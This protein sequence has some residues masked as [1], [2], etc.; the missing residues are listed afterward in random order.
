MSVRT[1]LRLTVTMI[2][3]VLAGNAMGQDNLQ[4]YF[5]GAA[6]KVKATANPEQK[7]EILNNS[8]QAMSTAL[9]RVES[10]GL[11]SKDDRAG[12]DRFKASLQE[13]QDELMGRNGYERVPDTQLNAFSNYVVQDM[14]QAEKMVTI[15]LVALL[16]IVI[17]VILIA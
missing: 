10:S 13:K 16:L 3:L 7:R 8:L 11:I 14:E 5:N 6:V 9:D 15:S 1:V 4:K 2:V 12:I 17:I